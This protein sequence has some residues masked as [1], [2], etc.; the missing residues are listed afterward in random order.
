MSDVV[1]TGGCGCGA[2]RFRA[3]SEPKRVAICHCMNC[4]KSHGTPFNVLAI[5][6][7]AQVE[8][9]GAWRA[10][11]SS[12]TYRRCFCTACGSRVFGLE[13]STDECELS[14]GSFDDVAIFAPQY[15]VWTVHREPWLPSFGIPQHAGGRPTS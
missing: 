6:E 13:D 1:R 7:P 14:L 3:R 4:R 15:E 5:Y 10:W 12:Q 9:T 2:L 8:I 11:Q